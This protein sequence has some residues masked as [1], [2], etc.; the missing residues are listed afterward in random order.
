MIYEHAIDV[1]FAAIQSNFNTRTSNLHIRDTLEW[2]EV[3]FNQNY[4][5]NNSSAIDTYTLTNVMILFMDS[6]SITIRRSDTIVPAGAS[7]MERIL[8]KDIVEYKIK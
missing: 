7:Y 8:L 5:Y 2:I 1:A 4:K 6:K 3:R